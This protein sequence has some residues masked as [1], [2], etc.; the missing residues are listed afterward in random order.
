MKKLF[1][2]KII[3]P[4][5]LLLIFA[6]LFSILFIDKYKLPS[7]NWSR[8][9]KIESYESNPKF[10]T[11]Y[12]PN[13]DLLQ[14]NNHF[15]LIYFSK[16]SLYL[17]T[18]DA[19]FNL[20]S[21]KK[22][23]SKIDDIRK[24]QNLSLVTENNSLSLY[25]S[26]QDTVERLNFSFG[27]K[28]LK[29][30]VLYQNVDKVK[31]INNSVA[32]IK[33]NHLYINNTKVTSAESLIKF[34]FQQYNNTY[35]VTHMSFNLDNFTKDL[36]L[37]MVTE[38]ET[39]SLMIKD[40]MFTSGANLSHIKINKTPTHINILFVTGDSKNGMYTNY[41]L[42][43]DE[44][45]KLLKEES[46]A[47][48]GSE[49]I[50]INQT[51]P[52]YIQ[53][54]STYIGRCD[55]STKNQYFVNTVKFKN[56]QQFP[57]TKTTSFAPKLKY[58]STD[59]YDYLLFTQYNN[60]N[61]YIS[62]NNPVLVAKSKKLDWDTFAN[63]L[64]ITLT[65]YSPTLLFFLIN[66]AKFVITILVVLFPLFVIKMYWVEDNWKKVLA[67]SI[68]IFILLKSYHV[69]TQLELSNLPLLFTNTISQLAISLVF[70]GIAFYCMHDISKGKNLSVINKFLI[71]SLIDITFFTLFFTPYSVI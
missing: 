10:K 71:F 42:Q 68:G 51:D 36:Y 48:S 27:G 43:L 41:E 57:L 55:V 47:S 8:E 70:S 7:E 3:I 23:L 40:F 16:E 18:Y 17:N 5:T 29:K 69:V 1:N 39:Q 12:I 24:Y 4:L 67:V 2:Y 14:H 21:E 49:P 46:Y 58:L 26:L 54:T 60:N 35:Y 44:N 45:N 32:Y 19:Q 62:S 65:T 11:R 22:I 30:D 31:I 25:Y 38:N 6:S 20:T 15:Y 37:S 63:L 61:I 56:N 33:D 66:F 59:T 9:I 64:V 53:K 13:M 28:N 50:F 34:D 52:T